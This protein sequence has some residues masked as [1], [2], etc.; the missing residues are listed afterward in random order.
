LKFDLCGERETMQCKRKHGDFSLVRRT[1]ALKIT[2]HSVFVNGSG[3]IQ[4]PLISSFEKTRHFP[5]LSGSNKMK[6]FEINIVYA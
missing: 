2:L 4:L 1:N 6:S 5:T 3:I